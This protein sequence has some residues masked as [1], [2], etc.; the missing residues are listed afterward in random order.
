MIA[1][2]S[3]QN[4]P[5]RTKELETLWEWFVTKS[6]EEEVINKIRKNILD[7]WK[8][9]QAAGVDPKQLQTKP[10]LSDLQLNNLLEESELFQVAKPIIDDLYPKM[11]GT[12]YL[13]TLNDQYGRMIYLKGESHIMKLAEKMNFAPG[14][15][16][17][18]QAA[19]TNAIGTS[20]VTK[21]PIQ[22]LSAE[23]FCQGCHPWTCSSAPIFHP[24]TKQVIGAIDITGLWHNAQPHTLGFAVSIA[25]MIEKQLEYAYM[26]VNSFLTEYYYQSVKKWKSH[27]VLVLTH[28]FQVFKND[29]ALFDSL[30]LSPLTKL[31]EKPL[32]R[33][34]VNELTT[35]ANFPRQIYY[36]KQLY[37]QDFEVI[38]LE[39]IL[40]NREIA[41]YMI[42][43]KEYKIATPIPSASIDKDPWNNI[44]GRSEI[45]INSLSKCRKAAL[46]NV[47]ILLMGESGTGKEVIAQ[48]IHEASHRKNQ[49]FIAINCG[50]IQ[51]ELIGSELFGYERG[52]FTGARKD[53]KKG[54]F[55]EANGGTLFLD[56]IGEMPIDLQ[57]HLLRVLQEKEVTRIG[58]S[59]PIPVNVRII[60]ATN[61]DLHKLI[62]QGQFR[63]DLFFRLN[64]VTVNFPP[65][66]ERKED[67]PLLADYFLKQFAEK[68]EKQSLSFAK[69]TLEF[70][71]NYRWPGNIRE[72]QNALEHAVI[73]SDTSIINLVNLP[74]Y[75]LENRVEEAL[76]EQDD[77]FSLIEQEEKKILLQLLNETNWNVSAVAKRMN[78]A[79]STLYRKL[80]K[81]E[82]SS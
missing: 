71:N 57:V 43:F 5:D 23:H 66:R 62:Q 4:L 16:W 77:E 42:V 61:K 65:L 26:Q 11:T 76:S 74:S 1:I 41:G 10:A 2:F 60:A 24:L 30:N 37:V 6:K 36:D 53:G 8:R 7:S 56:E 31:K 13:I 59:K 72:L 45:F 63:D 38:Y 58:S 75:L 34:L 49:P 50:A 68:Y 40:F 69:E 55:E 54:K 64:V 70:L 9:C 52:S 28:D 80:K 17:S 20:I 44:I 35:M 79:R 12:G 22:I 27:H 82:I 21:S 32:F 46:A 18:E 73:F 19:G 78:I 14:M 25:Q 67:I 47:P 81:Y 33:S 51:K 3:I 15:D 39:P 48:T 29:G